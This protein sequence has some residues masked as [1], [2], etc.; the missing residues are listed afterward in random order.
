MAPCVDWT[1]SALRSQVLRD[2]WA[3]DLL[4]HQAHRSLTMA[5]DPP[6]TLNTEAGATSASTAAT[7]AAAASETYVKS[8]TLL[9]VAVHGPGAAGGDRGDEA[10]EGNVADDRRRAD[11]SA[12]RRRDT[13]ARTPVTTRPGRCTTAR[14]TVGAVRSPAAPMGPSWP[15]RGSRRC[16][17]AVVATVGA[18]LGVRDDGLVIDRSSMGFGTNTSCYRDHFSCWLSG[19]GRHG[20]ELMVDPTPKSGA[21]CR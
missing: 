2:H 10:V 9:A 5:S 12:T 20:G 4:R 16:P 7:V 1:S 17:C 14:S 11:G 6:S 19:R 13:A 8:R 15:A 21:S 18:R 3:L